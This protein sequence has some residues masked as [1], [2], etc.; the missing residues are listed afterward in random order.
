MPRRHRCPRCGHAAIERTPH[1]NPVERL[2]LALAEKRPY[3]CRECDLR[4][5]D[6]PLPKLRL[7]VR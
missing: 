5:Y 3:R 2:Y 4:F 6:R 1:R 7:V